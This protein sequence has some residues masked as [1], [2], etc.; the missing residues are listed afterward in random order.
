MVLLEQ[1]GCCLQFLLSL[2]RVR[3]CVY[4]VVRIVSCGLHRAVFLLVLRLK[5][6]WLM[7]MHCLEF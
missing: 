4:D 5:G 6:A 2:I 3:N 1:S 7:I